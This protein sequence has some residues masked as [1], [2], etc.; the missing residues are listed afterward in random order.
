MIKLIWI[1]LLVSPNTNL[2]RNV[3]FWINCLYYTIRQRL[4]K[5]FQHSTWVKNISLPQVLIFFVVSVIIQYALKFVFQYPAIAQN[6]FIIRTL[7]RIGIF[8]H[9]KNRALRNFHQ[10]FFVK[11][12]FWAD[13][14][15]FRFFTYNVPAY[16]N[17]IFRFN[18]FNSFNDIH[19]HL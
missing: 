4:Q 17:V 19:N 11:W 1:I 9:L 18:A 8:K 10:C 16:R 12:G 5:A 6:A 14:V 15:I 7:E 2:H 3:A 13:I